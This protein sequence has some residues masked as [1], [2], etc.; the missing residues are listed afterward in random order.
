MGDRLREL[1]ENLEDLIEAAMGIK[2]AKTRIQ[3][4]ANPI[5]DHLIKILRWEDKVNYKKHIRD[6]NNWLL[7]IQ[8]LRRKPRGRRFKRRVYYDLLYDEPVG[9]NL[10]IVE[11]WIYKLSLGYGKLK[12]IRSSAEVLHALH[13]IYQDVSEELSNGMFRTIENNLR[14]ISKGQVC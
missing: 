5:L 9:N 14:K 2:D 11:E 7:E 6:I 13:R 1:I 12:E 4:L 8:I 10:E 3:G